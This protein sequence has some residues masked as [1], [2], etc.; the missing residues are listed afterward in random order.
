MSFHEEIMNKRVLPLLLLSLCIVCDFANGQAAP[1]AIDWDRARNLYQRQRGGEK[2]SPEDQAYLDRAKAERA[3]GA[4]AGQPGR[5][6]PAP[7]ES[8]GLIPLSNGGDGDG[9]YKG[10]KLGLYGDA[11]NTPPAAQQKRAGEAAAKIVPLDAEGHA[12]T[13]GRIVLM[14]VGMSNTTQ[15]FSRFVQVASGDPAKNPKLVIVDAAQGGRAADDWVKSDAPTWQ[16]ADHRLS[17]AQVT[18]KQVQVL[19]IK[20]ARKMPASLGE[21]PKHAQLLQDDLK[22][23]VLVAKERYPNLKLIYL[24]SRT[25]GGLATTALNPEP[26]AYES[27]FSVQWLIQ[28]QV[29][30]E[31]KELSNPTAPVLL[32]GPYLWTDGVKGRAADKLVWNKDDTRQDGTH[33]SASGQQKVADQLLEFFKSDASAKPWFTKL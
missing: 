19:W 3:K 6:A 23:I 7:R 1:P 8:T 18:P 2:L 29:K 22:H 24:S 5:A 15:E 9:D 11:Q 31:D 14:S 20:Q 25:Y 21:F 13:D 28:S 32:W 4:G 12:A 33:P 27:A 30:G 17:A 16:E 26:Y 10:F